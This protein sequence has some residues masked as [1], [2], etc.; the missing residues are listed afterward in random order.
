MTGGCR[1]TGLFLQGRIA[2]GTFDRVRIAYDLLETRRSN[3]DQW[4]VLLGDDE[5]E[6]E[7]LIN[8]DSYYLPWIASN[9]LKI[10]SP[11]GLISE[12]MKIGDFIAEKE[13]GVVVPAKGRCFSS[14]V[15]IY[16]AARTRSRVEMA[17]I[18]VHRPF[19]SEVSVELLSYSQYL[20]KYSSLTPL[21]KNYFSKYGVSPSLVD[22]MNT[23][24]SDDIKLLSNEELE[25]FGLG[26]HNVAAKELEKAKTIQLCGIDYH[27]LHLRYHATVRLCR[28]E[29]AKSRVSKEGICTDIADTAMPKYREKADR[30]RALKQ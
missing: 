19:A 9:T 6:Q 21:L 1:L 22:T 29:I 10:N 7:S 3:R 13:M 24:P 12:A 15:F 16:S 2:K 11:G 8:H 17:D 27:E 25:S 23:T 5:D 18:G 14:C 28:N 20:E 26:S 4:D 30:C